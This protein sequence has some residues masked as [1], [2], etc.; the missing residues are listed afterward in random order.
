[1][2]WFNNFLTTLVPFMPRMLVGLI[3]RKYIAGKTLDE[4]TIEIK[5]LNEEGFLT[6]ADILGEN[7]GDTKA[8]QKPVQSYLTLL[9]KIKDAGLLSGISI[10]LSQLGLTHDVEKAW[11]NFHQILMKAKELHLFIRIDMEDSPWTDQTIGFYRRAR[12][13]YEN[14]GTVIQAYL[15]RSEKDIKEMIFDGPTNLRICKGIYREPEDISIKDKEAVRQNYF[16][17]VKLCLDNDTFVAIATHD[18][19]LINTCEAY[20]KNNDIAKEKYEFQA[21]LGVPVKKTMQKLLAEGHRVRYYVP[22][23]QDWY[24][25]SMRRL[26]ENPSIAGYIFKD[27]FKFFRP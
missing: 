2:K 27:F 21:L 14:V 15:Y 8:A 12:D 20:L 26:K 16:N 9:Q 4:A 19:E 23:G 25:Y 3:A 7:I 24:P 10:K 13:E 17:L 22:F 11:E 18:I 1:M 6:T 5:K